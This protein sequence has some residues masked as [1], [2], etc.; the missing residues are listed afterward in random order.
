MMYR[1]ST[2]VYY[3]VVKLVLILLWTALQAASQ[4]VCSLGC[5]YGNRYYVQIM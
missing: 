4:E 2:Q 5:D 1:S 3:F